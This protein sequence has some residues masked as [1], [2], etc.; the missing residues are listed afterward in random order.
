MVTK[1]LVHLMFAVILVACSYGAGGEQNAAA[2]STQ[3]TADPCADRES[4]TA[5]DQAAETALQT[6]FDRMEALLLDKDHPLRE[7][8]EGS[9]VR[10]VAHA[11][12]LATLRQLDAKRKGQLVQYLWEFHLVGPVSSGES[13]PGAPVVSLAGADLSG[14]TLVHPNLAGAFLVK[15]NLSGAQLTLGYL[16][17]ANLARADLSGASWFRR[18]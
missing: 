9:E 17:D 16:Q 13:E 11:R 4:D 3:P 10:Q 6:Y 12:T 8:A 7:S 18:V 2:P 5:R 14:V 1:R 15:A